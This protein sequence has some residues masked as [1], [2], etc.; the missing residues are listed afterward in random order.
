MLSILHIETKVRDSSVFFL[1]PFPDPI[2]YLAHDRWK[3]IPQTKLLDKRVKIIYHKSSNELTLHL[4]I[5]MKE[6]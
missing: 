6:T 3:S 1:A 4:M 2:T 5:G